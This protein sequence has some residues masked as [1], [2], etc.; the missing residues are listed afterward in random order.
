MEN[1]FFCSVRT[2]YATLIQT[3][4]KKF[5]LGSTILWDQTIRA[6][7]LRSFMPGPAEPVR[8]V[9]PKPD[10]FFSAWLGIVRVYRMVK[11]V[12]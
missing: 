5:P 3:L 8:L 2:F 9:R 6:E 7:N 4:V 12:R 10:H 1:S 11:I